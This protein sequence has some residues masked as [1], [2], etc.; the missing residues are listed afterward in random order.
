MVLGF[1]LILRMIPHIARRSFGTRNTILSRHIRT[2]SFLTS[3]NPREFE[4]GFGAT[5]IYIES[6]SIVWFYTGRYVP[7]ITLIT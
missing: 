7:V 6:S 1:S 4:D 5:R 3:Y 2:V